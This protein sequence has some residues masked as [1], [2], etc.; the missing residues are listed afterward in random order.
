MRTTDATCLARGMV[1]RVAS[2]MLCPQETAD[3]LKEGRWLRLLQG[4]Q[5]R[6]DCRRVWARSPPGKQR[7]RRTRDADVAALAKELAELK[8]QLVPK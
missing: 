2:G 4:A 5:R 6:R 1:Q 3:E 8:L 7:V